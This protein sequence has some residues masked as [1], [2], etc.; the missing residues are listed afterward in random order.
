[1]E[2]DRRR[3]KFRR[4][5]PKYKVRWLYYRFRIENVGNRRLGNPIVHVDVGQ[6]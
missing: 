5:R 1:M 2:R 6:I 3:A 4:N